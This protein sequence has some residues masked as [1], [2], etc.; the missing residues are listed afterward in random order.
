MTRGEMRT[1]LENLCLED[2]PPKQDPQEIVVTMLKALK[3][4][5][6]VESW[7]CGVFWYRPVME[8]SLSWDG[9]HLLYRYVPRL[10]II[11]D[12]MEV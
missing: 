11:A 1:A 6:L 4:A 8:L 2:L 10:Y 5:G 9:Q 7:S 12:V 3:S